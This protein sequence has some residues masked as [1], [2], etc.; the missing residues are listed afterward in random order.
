MEVEGLEEKQRVLLH[1]LESAARRESEIREETTHLEKSLTMTKHDLKEVSRY[2]IPPRVFSCDLVSKGQDSRLTL[3]GGKSS[4]G[5][6]TLK[7]T[8]C[9]EFKTLKNKLLPQVLTLN[10]VN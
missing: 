3:K 5:K 6:E 4:T 9:S 8:C 10:N 2:V 7:Q 1:Q